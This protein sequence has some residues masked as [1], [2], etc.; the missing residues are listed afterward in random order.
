M[1]TTVR[2]EEL[3]WNH[4]TLLTAGGPVL[5]YLL[6]THFLCMIINAVNYIRIKILHVRLTIHERAAVRTTLRDRG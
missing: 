2:K 4:C 1:S 3:G 5:S 6:K